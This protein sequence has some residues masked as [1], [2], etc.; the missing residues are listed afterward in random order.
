MSTPEPF[1]PLMRFGEIERLVSKI[2]FRFSH[3]FFPEPE[4]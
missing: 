3:L 1:D 4:L 2:Y